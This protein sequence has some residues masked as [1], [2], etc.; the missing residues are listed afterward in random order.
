M[1]KKIIA[2]IKNALQNP[3]TLLEI[4]KDKRCN[5]YVFGLKLGQNS[6]KF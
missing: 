2:D 5:P 4:M 3:Q 1:D 6:G